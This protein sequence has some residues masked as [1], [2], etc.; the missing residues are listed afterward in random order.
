[1]KVQV[2]KGLKYRE[3]HAECECDSV[4]IGVTQQ[5]LR[6][7][8]W[9]HRYRDSHIEKHINKCVP[10]KAALHETYDKPRG[11]NVPDKRTSLES[12]FSILKKTCRTILTVSRLKALI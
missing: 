1:M 4:Y 12:H 7:R 8:I 10:Y 3:L 6:N 11:P 5:C 2:C 9:Q